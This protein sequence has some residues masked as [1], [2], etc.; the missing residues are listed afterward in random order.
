MKHLK[1]TLETQLQRVSC[2]E[3]S[4]W[5]H[6]LIKVLDLQFV[7][8]SWFMYWDVEANFFVSLMQTGW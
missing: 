6:L 1:H 3:V 8:T 7:V 4:I 2:F 5:D